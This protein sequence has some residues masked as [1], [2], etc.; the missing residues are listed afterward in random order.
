MALIKKKFCKSWHE[1]ESPL[2]SSR[3]R[4]QHQ[5]CIRL[6]HAK[7]QRE[8]LTSFSR[9]DFIPLLEMILLASEGMGTSY[10]FSE[11]L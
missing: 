7:S 1:D 3:G 2:E 4:G 9:L 10:M 5:I 8:T 11:M 6:I